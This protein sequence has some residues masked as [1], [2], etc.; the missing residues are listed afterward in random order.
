MLQSKVESSVSAHGETT[1][2]ARLA[3]RRYRIVSLHIAGDVIN[4]VVGIVILGDFGGVHVIGIVT[5]GKHSYELAIAQVVVK[6][7][8]AKPVSGFATEAVEQIDDTEAFELVG[9]LGT[10]DEVLFSAP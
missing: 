2:Q 3:L 9:V 8:P 6:M 10:D 7:R 5:L 1:D 4:D